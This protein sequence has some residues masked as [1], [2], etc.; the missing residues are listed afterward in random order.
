MIRLNKIFFFGGMLCFC[1]T[2]F[3]GTLLQFDE[4]SLIGLRSNETVQGYFSEQTG[5]GLFQCGFFFQ[6]KITEAQGENDAKIPI[7]LFHT[8]S[9]YDKRVKELDDE[10]YLYFID[11]NWV[12]QSKMASADCHSV[13]AGLFSA[14]DSKGW[15]FSVAKKEQAFGILTLKRKSNILTQE[16][17]GKIKGHLSAGQVVVLL[18]EHNEM[19]HIKYKISDNE[20]EFS[21]GWVNRSN[22]VNPFL[23]GG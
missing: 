8:P 15:P 13:D 22:L 3:A 12:I 7:K 21:S 4:D 5:T 14:S 9:T 18:N 1:A 6:G 11:G 17:N 19:A 16:K 20:N 23:N 10:G 2:S